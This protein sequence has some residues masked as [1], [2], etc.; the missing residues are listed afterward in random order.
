MTS[1]SFAFWLGLGSAAALPLGALVGLG[2]TPSSRMIAVI[3]GFGSGSLVAAL[4][5]ELVAEALHQSGFAPMALGAI[6]GGTIFLLLN[7]ALNAQGGFLRKPSTTKQVLG[8]RYREAAKKILT[9]LSGVN[10]LRAL[11]PE[12]VQAIV[13]FVHEKV[14]QT[15]DVIVQQGEEGDA[16]YVVIS[17]R[18]EVIHQ[19][20][21]GTARTVIR[22]DEPVAQLGSGEVFGEM[23]LLTGTGRSATV[24]AVTP[25]HVLIIFKKDFDR[26]IHRSP[27]LKSAVEHLREHR[28]KA[29]EQVQAKVGRQAERWLHHALQFVKPTGLTPTTG[30]VKAAAMR[31]AAAPLAICLGTVLDG[32]PESGVVG[33]S[34]VHHPA[35]N[36]S[37][38]AGIFLSNFP[39]SMSSAVGM[40]R[41]GYSRSLIFG[42]WFFLMMLTGVGAWAGNVLFREA[43]L[44]VFGLLQG[45]AAGAMLTMVTETMLPEAYEHGSGV[46]GMSTLLGFLATIFMR[47]LQ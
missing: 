30:E 46:V 25:L 47:T 3:M 22:Q 10:I 18:A 13:P 5:L 43:P 17:G 20:E 45:A 4:T 33:A 2:W 14:Y 35:V 8:Q 16:M 1:G 38:L 27:H 9:Q 21:V 39:E 15:G 36:W 41:I 23:A 19:L 32:I 37:L 40:R 29:L 42:M 6:G 31:H 12:E 28:E 26:L 44:S 34:L 24:K 7:H 11:P